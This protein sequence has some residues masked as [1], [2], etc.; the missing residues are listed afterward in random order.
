MERTS[1]PT[2]TV[3][4]PAKNEASNLEVMLPQLPRG[5]EVIV[6]DANSSDGTADVVRR[7]RPDAS[8]ITQTRK[9]KGNALSCGFS[10][11]TG[12]II[13]MFDADGSADPIEIPLFVDALVSGADFA[14]G[15]RFLPGGGSEDITPLRRAGNTGL[16]LTANLAFGTKFS[17]LC[18]GYNA[19]WRDMLPVLDLPEPGT[20]QPDLMLWGDGFEIETIINCRMAVADARIR[21]V[22]SVEKRRIHGESHLRTWADG[23]RVLRTLATE[24]TRARNV[25]RRSPELTPV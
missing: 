11:A 20:S 13:V 25:K 21:E 4:I 1:A 6:V 19:F 10:A 2:V 22:P 15:T 24:R 9:G 5:H 18:C 3:V 14:K 12:D 23:T 17:D 8:L 16:N 7:L